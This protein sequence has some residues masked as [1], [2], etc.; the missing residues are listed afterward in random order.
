MLE[1]EGALEKLGRGAHLSGRE[2]T[3]LQRL[4]RDNSDD[5]VFSRT[6]LDDLGAAGT[7]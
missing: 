5:E 1:A 3:E 2:L 4:F 6:L 7:I